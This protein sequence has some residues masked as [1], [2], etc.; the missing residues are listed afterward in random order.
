MED[1]KISFSARTEQIMDAY[2]TG[3]EVGMPNR[4]TWIKLGEIPHN[5]AVTL[6][7]FF[8]MRKRAI[9]PADF[10][11]SN[12]DVDGQ[13]A[14]ERYAAVSMPSLQKAG[15][16]FLFVGPFAETFIGGSEDW[17][18]VAI[19][20]YPGPGGVLALFEDP[21]YRQAYVHRVAACA[22]QRVSLCIG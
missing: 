2:G 8:K 12:V 20:T 6:V 3:A 16:R 18:L 13:T 5:Q 14:F 21:N 17:D 19:G 7:N 15:G 11:E 10:I 22:E 9:Y 4:E 1:T